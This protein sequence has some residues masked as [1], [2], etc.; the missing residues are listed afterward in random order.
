MT[1]P[2][3]DEFAAHEV[4]PVPRNRFYCNPLA[5]ADPLRRHLSFGERRQRLRYRGQNARPVLQHGDANVLQ[6]DAIIIWWWPVAVAALKR[7]C[8]VEQPYHERW[9]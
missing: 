4:D 1:V 8:H 5:N 9:S 2:D 6:I 3:L 7:N